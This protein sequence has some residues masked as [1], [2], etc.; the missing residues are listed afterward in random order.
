MGSITGITGLSRL[1]YLGPNKWKLFI[2]MPDVQKYTTYA[3]LREGTIEECL[4]AV[5]KV[6]LM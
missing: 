3:Q 5:A 4:D 2:Y 6:Y 1:E